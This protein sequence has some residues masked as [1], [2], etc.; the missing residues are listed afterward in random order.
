M[1]SFKVIAFTFQ[2]FIDQHLG[3]YSI[4]HIFSKSITLSYKDLL[5]VFTNV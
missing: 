5:K 1:K 4:P 2:N 3:V